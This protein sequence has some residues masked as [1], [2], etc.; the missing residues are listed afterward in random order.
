MAPLLLQNCDV[1]HCH[2]LVHLLD[3]QVSHLNLVLV[4]AFKCFRQ[5]TALLIFTPNL[6]EVTT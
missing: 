5:K 6:T 3:P 1:G 4:N 2:H